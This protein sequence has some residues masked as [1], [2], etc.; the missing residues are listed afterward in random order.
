MIK[1]VTDQAGQ[2]FYD[3]TFGFW[4]WISSYAVLTQDECDDRQLDSRGPDY[5]PG[6]AA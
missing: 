1:T 5:S 6:T 2:A 3:N 4:R